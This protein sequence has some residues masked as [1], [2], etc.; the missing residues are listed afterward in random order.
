MAADVSL[1]EK[2]GPKLGGELLQPR[3]EEHAKFLNSL[4]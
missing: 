1:Q 3:G 4:K 2:S